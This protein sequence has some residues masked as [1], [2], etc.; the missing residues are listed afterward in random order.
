MM[1]IFMYILFVFFVIKASIT[2]ITTIIKITT[3]YKLHTYQKLFQET[4]NPTV[5]KNHNLNCAHKWGVLW[6]NKYVYDNV[7]GMENMVP[8][9][10]NI[11][12]N[13]YLSPYQQLPQKKN[14]KH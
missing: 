4:Q 5:D 14:E 7:G 13:I 1:H 11:W 3:N 12:L 10:C 8:L 6:K 9:G 2:S